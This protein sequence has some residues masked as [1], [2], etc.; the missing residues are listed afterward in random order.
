MDQPDYKSL[1]EQYRELQLRV[2]RFS[3]TQQE[4][5]NTRDRLDQELELYKR[6]NRFSQD[7]L[8][9]MSTSRFLQL[10]AEAMI[11]LLEVESSAAILFRSVE[12]PEPLLVHEGHLTSEN[13]SVLCTT[14]NT[15][16][17]KHA[18]TGVQLLSS[19][20]IQTEFKL[21]EFSQGLYLAYYDE[22]GDFSLHLIALISKGNAPLYPSLLP[23]HQTI[24][25]VFAQHASAILANRQK[26]KQITQ[27]IAV[28]Q[29]SERE[30][31]KLS[32]IATMT[33]NGVIITD[34]QGRIEWVNQSFE[35]TTGYTLIEVLGKKPRDFLQGPHTDDEARK[36]LSEALRNKEGIE[37]TLVN[38]DKSGRLYYNLLEI[39][40][41]F[42]DAG[43]HINF[44]AVQ[45]DITEET[46]IKEEIIRANSR[47]E[48]I[49]NKSG[50]GVWEST[51]ETGALI[52]NKVLAQLYAIP[53]G[54]TANEFRTLASACINADD[55]P[56]LEETMIRLRSGEID[57]AEL[58]FRIR[59]P[60]DGMTRIIYGTFLS[61]RNGL[62]EVVRVLGSSL[63]ITEERTVEERLRA[64]EAKYRG[65][66]ES[67]SL[68]LVE[69][70]LNGSAV[71]YNKQF[72]SLTQITVPALLVLNEMPELVLSSRVSDGT[73]LSYTRVEDS[74]F[75]VDLRRK[76][77]SLISLLLSSAPVLDENGS[78]SG[79][80][81]L[82]VDITST[83]LLRK[84][85]ETALQERD[86]FLRKVN[87]T[88]HFYESILNQSPSEMLVL[89][90][91]MKLL[92]ANQ[93]MRENE[94]L[95]GRMLDLYV[96]LKLG[97]VVTN[98]ERLKVLFE[99]VQLSMQLQQ[100]MQFE[101][102]REDSN[103]QRQ[104]ILRSILPYKNKAG[105]LEY[106]IISGTDISPLKRI[107]QDVIDKN[108]ELKKIN[109]ELDNFVYSISHDLRSPLLSIKGILGMVSEETTFDD[110]NRQLMSMALDSTDRLDGTIQ[111][112]LDYSRNS[113]TELRLSE[114][115]LADIVKNV[116]SDL[117]YAAPEGF[118]FRLEDRIKEKVLTDNYRVATLLKNIIGNAVKYRRDTIA[119]PHV[120]VVLERVDEYI[121]I[122]VI[123]NGSG[124]SEK[125]VGKVF[126]MFFRAN[127]TVTGTGLGL[128]ICREI[129]NRL[130]GK[131]NVNSIPGKGSTFTI[132]LPSEYDQSG[133]DLMKLAAD[134]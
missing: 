58:E 24:F 104:T 97:D 114:V 105:G 92:Y 100:L 14:L 83:K 118:M 34:N 3:A 26:R 82:Y 80:I 120:E 12:N 23:R 130:G 86:E 109:A 69:S 134:H 38:Y 117:R 119:D 59:R 29:E 28:I 13:T 16:V 21:A 33:K 132:L 85:L 53:P 20:H 88:K 76:D 35:Q 90:S 8:A 56:L 96:G 40:P 60:S 41:V 112:I 51:L 133:N 103:N 64:G 131:I 125:N 129:I 48:R 72:I 107:Q 79:Y 43:N 123:D 57:D 37:I 27:Q 127:I 32:L 22:E 62:G 77:G 124:I 99:K 84:N 10:V 122:Q 4:L 91:K 108:E 55:R 1:L 52:W 73:I 87:T 70:D 78:K 95:I 115:Y 25:G 30:L 11:E 110:Q 94:P 49:A 89:D 36:K 113:R 61:E 31:R 67:V 47:F 45:K 5:I 39:T 6:L 98:D 50:I 102:T 75:E 42:D 7:S 54:S 68:G 81:C 65:L 116:F 106:V 9:E 74:V 111:E 121:S 63:D 17:R 66:I 128:Y 101:E 71:Y 2:T 46:I 15:D 19:E 93:L 126:D 18:K 44:I